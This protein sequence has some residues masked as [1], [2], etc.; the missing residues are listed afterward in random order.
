[1]IR[2]TLLGF[3]AAGAAVL[4]FAAPAT[5]HEEIN[6][7]T[8]PTGK[9]T[10]FTLTAAN[11]KKS[12]L[13]KIGVTAPAGTP[14]GTTTHS[15][16]GWTVARSDTAI[17]WTGGKVAPDNFD[18]W[19]FEI[20]G[21][22]QPGAIKYTVNMGFADGS[23]DNVEVDV[24]AVGSAPGPEPT[25][26]SSTPGGTPASST[27]G[28]TTTVARPAASSG[29]GLAVAAIIVS[30]MAGLVAG[31]AVLI[32]MKRPGAPGDGGPAGD[33]KAAPAKGEDW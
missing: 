32:A 33:T 26:V 3:G 28:A 30:I 15:P 2:R 5:A 17:T 11:E 6:P 10:F 31:V 7:S 21:A 12:D 16:P 9:P 24:N 23:T 8:F 29:E 25:T 19:G 22:D 4:M 1:M 27:P 13:T 20:E 14:F 18:Q